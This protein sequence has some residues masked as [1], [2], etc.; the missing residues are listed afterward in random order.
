MYSAMVTSR[1]YAPDRVRVSLRWL[2]ATPA[3]ITFAACFHIQAASA[4]TWRG[5]VVEP[6]HRC[7]RYQSS[8]YCYLPSVERKIVAELGKIYSPYT[9]EC[10]DTIWQTDIEHIVARSEAH[11]SGLCAAD[12]QNPSCMHCQPVGGE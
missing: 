3:F 5:L 8:D 12:A 11:D 7:S 2:L 6:E 10:F 4:E 1:N 9:G